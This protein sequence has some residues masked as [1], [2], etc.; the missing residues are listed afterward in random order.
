M[1]KNFF[2]KLTSKGLVVIAIPIFFSLAFILLLKLLLNQAQNQVERELRSKQIIASANSLGS[3]VI[4][5]VTNRY[6]TRFSNPG[7]LDKKLEASSHLVM[8]RWQELEKLVEH[9]PKQKILVEHIGEQLRLGL[10]ITATQDF[11]RQHNPGLSQLSNLLE[12]R[13]QMQEIMAKVSADTNALIENEKKTQSSNNLTRKKYRQWIDLVLFCGIA[14]DLLMAVVL[15]S[16]FSNDITGRLS[17]IM[18]NSRKLAEEKELNPVIKG[19]DELVELDTVFHDMAARLAQSRENERAAAARIKSIVDTIPLGLIVIDGTGKISSLSPSAS[20]MFGYEARDLEGKLLTE[21]L[22]YGAPGDWLD[23]LLEE[24]WTSPRELVGLNAKGDKFPAEVIATKYEAGFT[25]KLLVLTDISQRYEMEKLK[26]SFVSIVSHELRSPLTSIGVCL[27]MLSKNYFGVLNEEGSQNVKLAERSVAR[28][29]LLVNEILDAERLESG[30]ISVAFEKVNLNEI[31]SEAQ[32]STK[33]I[34]EEA[35]I[36]LS[37]PTPDMA[38]EADRNRLVQVLVNLISNAI[39]FSPQGSKVSIRCNNN[40]NNNMLEVEV[41]DQGRGVPPEQRDL[42]F[43]RF[44]QVSTQDA[45][46]GG[47]GL[48]LAI[49]K[50]IIDAHEGQIGVRDN[51][52]GGSIFWFKIPLK[53]ANP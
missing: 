53:N 48:G 47:T 52:T 33:S 18:D 42:I 16:L 30:N 32:A 1:Q 37:F 44:H 20:V 34:A 19:D 27:K 3:S 49:C 2:S 36:D 28:L 26:Q 31:L 17:V 45:E 11:A 46:K 15:M 41:S 23:S 40:N 9:N 13:K 6:M 51:E 12:R 43:K 21:L 25:G 24:D 22:S 5:A 29:V 50:A 10:D 8:D 38:I 35:S 7:T 39:K 14:G 4:L